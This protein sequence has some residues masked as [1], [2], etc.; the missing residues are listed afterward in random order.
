MNGETIPEPNKQPID[1][2]PPPAYPSE[3][4]RLQA[5]LLME[6]L[7]M[8]ASSAAARVLYVKQLERIQ[9]AGLTR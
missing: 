7:V 8:T 5:E 1:D 3:K 6:E 4:A 9:R 2:A